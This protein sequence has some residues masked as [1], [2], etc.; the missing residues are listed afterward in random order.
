MRFLNDYNDVVLEA[1]L[2]AGALR[3]SFYSSENKREYMGRL[4][5]ACHK[6]FAS[7]QGVVCNAEVD[8]VQKSISSEDLRS[9]CNAADNYMA[10][11]R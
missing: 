11:Y 5:N 7:H 9:G 1:E 2:T 4:Q 8:Y 6:F 10:Q 3:S